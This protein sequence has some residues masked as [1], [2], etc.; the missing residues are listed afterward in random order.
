MSSCSGEAIGAPKPLWFSECAAA[1]EMTVY[2]SKCMGFQHY[3]SDKGAVCILMK[4]FK[5]LTEHKCPDAVW[6]E[7]L[8]VGRGHG[9]SNHTTK[10]TEGENCFDVK[11]GILYS[12][13][14]CGRA[15]GGDFD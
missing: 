9:V 10:E 1:C 8:Q 12:G 4:E 15:Y 7:L 13:Q 3:T 11:V 2:P 5:K 14:T 6:P